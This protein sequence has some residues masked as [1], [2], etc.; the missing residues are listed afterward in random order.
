MREARHQQQAAERMQQQRQGLVEFEHQQQQQ[1]ERQVFD[2]VAV[3]AHALA[4]LGV[5]A[6]AHADL[7]RAPVRDHARGE[8]KNQQSG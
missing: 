3:R 8:Y 7:V 4:Q 2:R 6:I 1:A 5:V